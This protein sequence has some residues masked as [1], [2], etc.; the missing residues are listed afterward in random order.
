M[1]GRTPGPPVHA[2]N[3]LVAGYFA[4][5]L[6]PSVVLC[7]PSRRLHYAIVPRTRERPFA[8]IIPTKTTDQ[9]FRPRLKLDARSTESRISSSAANRF[10]SADRGKNWPARRIDDA[11][12]LMVEFA[13]GVFPGGPWKKCALRDVANPRLQSTRPFARTWRR[14]GPSCTTSRMGQNQAECGSTFRR[15]SSA[16]SETRRD[17][18][19]DEGADAFAAMKWRMGMATISRTPLFLLKA[20]APDN[21][22]RD[23]PEHFGLDERRR[24]RGKWISQESVRIVCPRGK[25]TEFDSGRA[26]RQLSFALSDTGD[27]IIRALLVWRILKATRPRSG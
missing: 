9:I 10:H 6:T 22:R 1:L 26:K 5:R 21:S 25:V 19:H 14:D 8:R 18:H 15:R 12:G 11:L 4:R 24:P 13:E 20:P 17:R 16:R 2:G 23:R 3:A 27:G 7:E